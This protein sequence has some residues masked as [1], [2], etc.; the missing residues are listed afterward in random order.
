MINVI[1]MFDVKYFDFFT[2]VVSK[3]Y[4]IIQY[5]CTFKIYYNTIH[6]FSGQK[7]D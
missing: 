1:I 2:R 4:N 5:L 7:R 6:C 3:I